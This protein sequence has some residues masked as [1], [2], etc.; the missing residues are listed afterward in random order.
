MS[1]STS[2][3]IEE[4]KALPLSDRQAGAHGLITELIDNAGDIMSREDW[5][6]LLA[7]IATSCDCRRECLDEEDEA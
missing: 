4:L 6:D 1:P 5:Y 7:E 3:A 2:V